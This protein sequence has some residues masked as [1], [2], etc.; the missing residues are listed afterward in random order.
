MIKTNKLQR[1]KWPSLEH[2]PVYSTSLFLLPK[3]D[4]K[5]IFLEYLYLDE[6]RLNEGKHIIMCVVIIKAANRVSYKRVN[7]DV[8]MKLEHIGL[9]FYRQKLTVK[10]SPRVFFNHH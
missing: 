8:A 4:L 6:I 9:C 10:M 2:F 1:L 5:W 3:I 7:P